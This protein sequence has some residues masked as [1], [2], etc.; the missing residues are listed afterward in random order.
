MKTRVVFHGKMAEDL[1]R[2]RW[3]LAISTPVEALRAVEAIH[4]GVFKHLRENLD[5][6]Y[7]LLV[8]GREI[9][10]SA[11]LGAVHPDG[12][13][14]SVDIMPVPKGAG[15]G[16]E[17]GLMIL[18]G[19]VLLAAAIF[20]PG[21][22][23]ATPLI[24]GLV[25]S[26][27]I[28][29]IFSGISSML[30]PT[31]NQDTGDGDRRPS[32]IFN[33]A[34]NTMRQGNP[35]PLGVGAML[36]GSQVISMGV[37]ARAIDVDEAPRRVV[38]VSG[39]V[40]PTDS[41]EIVYTTAPFLAGDRFECYQPSDNVT[42][43]T[44]GNGFTEAWNIYIGA[45][46]LVAIDDWD[47][48]PPVGEASGILNLGVGFSE[49]WNTFTDGIGYIIKDTFS[50]YEPTDLYPPTKVFGFGV[51]WSEPWARF[52]ADLGLVAED[53][54]ATYASG[55]PAPSYALGDGTGFS[56]DW[57]RYQIPNSVGLNAVDR[58][59]TYDVGLGFPLQMNDGEF[60]DDPWQGWLGG[61]TAGILVF[62]PFE[63]YDPAIYPYD[64]YETLL[65]GGYNFAPG[66]DWYVY[67]PY[68]LDL[69][70][71]Y[72]LGSNVV[73][74]DLNGGDGFSDTWEGYGDVAGNETNLLTNGDFEDWN[75]FTPWVVDG[76]FGVGNWYFNN[77][78]DNHNPMSSGLG[79]NDPIAGNYDLMSDHSGFARLITLDQE[80]T[81]PSE[82]VTAASA[83]W[84]DFLRCN[85]DS[86]TGAENLRFRARIMSK[87]QQEA[88]TYSSP[89]LRSD[90]SGYVGA[91]IYALS[92]ADFYITHI[93]RMCHAGNSGTHWIGLVYGGFVMRSGY[94]DTSL[95]T[96]GQMQYLTLAGTGFH[97]TPSMTFY[98][99]SQEVSGGDSFGE[100]G[101]STL[102]GL[103]D[104]ATQAWTNVAAANANHL[105]VWSTAQTGPFNAGTVTPYG[106]VGYKIRRD[107][108]NLTDLRSAGF[109]ADYQDTVA[110]DHDID[111]TTLIN[112]HLGEDLIWRF[113]VTGL[114]GWM[115]AQVDDV[116]LWVE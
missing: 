102:T 103:S 45:P 90:F 70:G 16:L 82:A 106:P 101:T 115:N 60:W 80:F 78:V 18:L 37:Y 116:G 9:E 63:E 8:N 55:Y 30:A 48:Y 75:N 104:Y 89:S 50:F 7:I 19:V 92:Y 107:Y 113:D 31:K 68:P 2:A 88:L 57:S 74:G 58:F 51:G 93:G 108:V 15:S 12:K 91:K 10:V 3:D 29:L 69:F 1:G 23:A 17:A 76:M 53:D 39:D 64:G 73:P 109:E 5:T 67:N 59:G 87:T 94:L 54:F 21:F 26:V 65:N 66:E 38:Q 86:G 81:V 46:G 25:V 97:V 6:E 77:G 20:I 112:N 34:L 13:L 56:E 114:T 83:R 49:P 72:V 40:G 32:Y 35:V 98:I 41:C 42:A 52:S 61:L 110:G 22:A 100:A 85:W 24:Y 4:G 96:P 44:S 14:R 36:I 33:G 43:L 47:G 111:V 84:K 71:G 28:S 27:G 95:G 99:I 105:N 11:E 62:D 79:Y